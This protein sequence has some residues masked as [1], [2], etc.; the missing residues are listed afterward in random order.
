MNELTERPNYYTIGFGDSAQAIPNSAWVHSVV[1]PIA[2]SCGTL[3]NPRAVEPV[4]E[5]I[6]NGPLNALDIRINHS[7]SESTMGTIGIIRKD[8]RNALDEF[9][10]GGFSKAFFW[11]DVKFTKKNRSNVFY[12]FLNR[13][14]EIMLS[15]RGGKSSFFRFCEN[16]GSPRYAASGGADFTCYLLAQMVHEK[17]PFYVSNVFSL[18]VRADIADKLKARR[19]GKLD[20]KWMPVRDTPLDG[21]PIELSELPKDFRMNL[22]VRKS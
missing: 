12:A 14:N 13:S 10:F 11:G 3:L 7:P 19:I 9:S 17:C 16:C 15:P 4:V 20:L 6:D 2:C 21:L 18:F 8:L 1:T 5:D 22:P